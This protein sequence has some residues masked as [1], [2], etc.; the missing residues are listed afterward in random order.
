[1]NK[2]GFT[3]IELLAVIIIFGIISTIAVGAY[4]GYVD[5]S[6]KKAYYSAEDT[7]IGATKSLLTSCMTD[8]LNINE[9]VSV[10]DIGKST[11]VNLE[12]L[13]DNN[14]MT[15]VKDQNESGK[16]SGKVRITNNRTNS[17]NYN[18]E[19]TVCLKCSDYQSSSC[20]Y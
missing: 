5:K 6:K 12:T 9:C 2:K 20:W 11:D 14:F 4:Y 16:C 18:L 15:I 8:D 19:Y 17:D 7:M 10:P 3:L 13:I 1:M